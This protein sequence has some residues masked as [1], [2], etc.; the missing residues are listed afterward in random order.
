[1]VTLAP[2]FVPGPAVRVAIGIA[3]L[4]GLAA[5]ASEGATGTPRLAPL[6]GG[7]TPLA[8]GQHAGAEASARAFAIAIGQGD[9]VQ[10]Q[11]VV[12]LDALVGLVARDLPL[13]EAER[14][15]LI[16]GLREGLSGLAARMQQSAPDGIVA[17][18]AGLFDRGGQTRALL[19]LDLGEHGLNYF[20][21]K[22]A[23]GVDG[24]VRVY[25]WYDYA[26]GTDFSAM[27]AQLAG[28]MVRDRTSLERAAEVSSL[29][30]E[31]ADQLIRF[32][33]E[34]RTDRYATALATF[35]SMPE[36]LR[37]SR[38]LLIQ[39]VKAASRV[40]GEGAY[41]GALAD[42]AHHHGDDP[43]L[44]LMLADH[45]FYTGDRDRLFEVL[46]RLSAFLGREDAGLVYMDSVYRLLLGEPALAER[47]ALRAMALEPGY[48]SP[49]WILVQSLLSQRKFARVTETLR[50]MGTRFGYAFSRE[51]F[52]GRREFAEYLESPSFRAWLAQPAMPAVPAKA[53]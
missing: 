51:N 4:I 50:E 31:E 24:R 18:Y 22:L 33:E 48:E 13:G 3:C 8:A 39:R 10:V 20:E 23:R 38:A 7:L 30:D 36:S 40:K 34:L 41:Q 9:D 53:R 27:V 47:A 26:Q 43:R 11:Q 21:L 14:A 37:R 46:A 29:T 28:L 19:R 6:P 16:K 35:E 32:I 44:A 45:Y 42:L 1:M 12:S 5:G 2:R 15:G 25:D 49:Y 52:E 17:Y